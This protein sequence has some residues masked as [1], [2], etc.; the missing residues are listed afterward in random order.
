M[1][2]IPDAEKP[3]LSRFFAGS[4]A[5]KWEQ[6]TSG[7][8][9]AEWLSQV[10]SWLEFLSSPQLDRPLLLP[11]F[12]ENG[13]RHWYAVAA[14]DQIAA[15]LLE[16]VRA[17]IGPSFS[18]FSG[19]WHSLSDSDESERALQMRFGWRT[20]RIDLN[21]ENDRAD[22]ERSIARYRELLS[23]RPGIPDRAMRPFGEVRN[24]FDLALLAGNVDRA[25]HCLE[26]LVGSGR[27][28]ADQ[29][30]FLQIRFL[31]G[32]GR[33]EEIARDRLLIESVMNLVLPPQT[34]VDLVEALYATY[35]EPQERELEVSALAAMFRQ[36]ISHPFGALFRERKGI[37]RPRV[38]R[39][40][41]L[42]EVGQRD[43][44]DVRCGALVDAYP[45]DDAGFDLVQR[46]WHGLAPAKSGSPAERVRQAIGDEDYESA[47]NLAFQALPQ[48]WAYSALLRCAVEV[49]PDELRTRVTEAVRQIDAGVLAS[50]TDRD[51]AR[52]RRLVASVTQAVR[53][54]AESSWLAW[55]N[56]VTTRPDEWAPLE[57]LS[58]AVLK[59][60][61]STYS[62]DP[63]ACTRL[64]N[65]IGNAPE[66]GARVF[67]DAFPVMIDFFVVRPEKPMRAFVSIYSMLIR[68]IAWSSPV[69]ADELEIGASL[70]RALLATGPDKAI[71][72]ECLQD[73]H[74]VITANNAPVHLDWAL[75]LAE[76]LALYPSHD[77]ELRL[78]I[79]FSI[80][81]MCR[82]VAHRLTPEQ[83]TVLEL[84]AADYGVPELLAELPPAARG[85]VDEDRA[86]FAGVIGIYTLN[87][88]AGQRARTA[89]E[90]LMPSAR[91]EV[92]SDTTASDRLRHLAK[93]ADLFVF[94]WKTSTHQAF[95]CA[96]DARKDRDII[97]PSGGGTASLV[98][99]VLA[100][101]RSLQQVQR[102]RDLR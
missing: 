70:T 51:R 102:G 81:G 15:Q 41:F 13:T 31:A 77:P 45:K 48:T 98:R 66:P 47:A 24:D 19:H 62:T 10:A 46:W 90:R 84:L 50:L 34:I 100:E 28:G 43:R 71:Y 49:E 72:T 87:E 78:R 96:K 80:F 54:H 59:W 42:F 74:E 63:A 5:L 35:V 6:I 91:V 99:S 37:R 44:N 97:M 68:V 3:W 25:Q 39:A 12:A 30:K 21:A 16:E 67:R 79:F 20:L 52:H 2:P 11:M 83:R 56:D 76:L 93:S 89:I 86:A 22:V 69:S 73:L 94:A 18:Q 64:A 57:V 85:D 4:N 23:R 65:L 101:V 36:H 60:D 38:L 32:L 8:A 61:V 92:N 55:A 75:S 88:P 27:I 17:F 14:N 26:E 40:F 95:Y 33:I 9:P 58:N 53:P 1:K 7:S 82:A 29:H